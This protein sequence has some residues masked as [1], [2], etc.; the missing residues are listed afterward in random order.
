MDEAMSDDV[1]LRA[2]FKKLVS[3]IGDVDVDEEVGLM[4]ATF[5]A[6]EAHEEQQWELNEMRRRLAEL[7]PVVDR[8]DDIG[9]EKTTK[10]QKIAAIVTYARNARSRD[11]ERVTV[12]RQNVQGAAGVSR[13]YS[14]D[15]IDD[16][17]NGDGQDGA[18]G[19]DGFDWALDPR[20]QPRHVEQ[21][22]PDTGVLIDFERLHEDAAAVNKFITRSGGEGGET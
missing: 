21:D 20:E 22:V 8:L 15:L 9:Q 18:V 11:Q 4:E 5:R 6:L 1:A 12:T 14:Y 16:M 19:P 10:E 17:I 3:E 7:E 2:A 13:R